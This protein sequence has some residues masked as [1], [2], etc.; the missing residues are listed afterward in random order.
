M[1]FGKVLLILK[2]GTYNGLTF[3][4]T[5]H[6]INQHENYIQGSKYSNEPPC[7]HWCFC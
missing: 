5:F 4:S 3:F 7:R 2:P 1:Y 6:L